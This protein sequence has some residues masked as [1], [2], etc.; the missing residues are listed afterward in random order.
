MV[1]IRDR[2]GVLGGWVLVGSMGGSI[3][4]GYGFLVLE[5]HSDGASWIL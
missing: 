1:N 4:L 3:P 2:D 5:Q